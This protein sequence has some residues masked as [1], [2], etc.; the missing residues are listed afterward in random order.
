[1]NHILDLDAS[2]Q[3]SHTYLCPHCTIQSKS[4]GH[5][6]LE[7][8]KKVGSGCSHHMPKRRTRNIWR[9]ATVS[10]TPL[11]WLAQAATTKQHR[12]EGL[13]NRN[14]LSHSCPT[15]PGGQEPKLNVWAE[16]GPSEGCSGL[17][18]TS[19]WLLATFGVPSLVEASLSICPHH[20]M[21]FHVCTCTHV[22]VSKFPLF[23]KLPLIWDW[24][25][26]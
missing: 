13:N 1:M 2:I 4:C 9:P 20:H 22:S 18:P 24:G 11:C 14:V 6:Q 26:S 10:A 15:I 16:L 19:C 8:A 17:S 21:A 7:W 12:L 3:N 23:T 25:P 5:P